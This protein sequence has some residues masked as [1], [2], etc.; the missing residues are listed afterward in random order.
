MATSGLVLAHLKLSQL[1]SIAVLAKSRIG[2][3]NV[4]NAEEGSLCLFA[5]KFFF[6]MR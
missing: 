6:L 4:N 3:S 1:F 2:I 5:G